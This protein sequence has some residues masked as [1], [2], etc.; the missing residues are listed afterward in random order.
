MKHDPIR[1]SEITWT[2]KARWPSKYWL[3]MRSLLL[4]LGK[5]GF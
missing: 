3:S 2:P 5:P 4:D 1:G